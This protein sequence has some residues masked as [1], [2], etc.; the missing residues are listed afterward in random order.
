M[1]MASLVNCERFSSLNTHP[2]G[3]IVSQGYE[4]SPSPSDVGFQLMSRRSLLAAAGVVAGAGLLAACGDDE[5]SATTT[6]ATDGATDTTAAGTETTAAATDTTAAPS[7]DAVTIGINEA[8]GTK[9]YDGIKA[10]LDATGVPY[11]GNFVDHNS[12]QDNI[13]SYL[14]QPDDVFTWF[15]LLYTSDAADE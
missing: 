3:G 5:E 10:G 13:T 7:G 1:F 4:Q 14:A 9:P 2:L 8:E 15:C 6:P 11:E 12:F